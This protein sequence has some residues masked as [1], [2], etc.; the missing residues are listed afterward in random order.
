M[1]QAAPDTL[2]T[3]PDSMSAI[4]LD[5]FEGDAS[6]EPRSVSVPDLG[7]DEVLIR[8]QSA[9]VGVW[10]PAELDGYFAE[11]FDA[12]PEFPYVPGFDGAGIVAAV[13]E[14]L[15]EFEPG[16]RVY[17]AGQATPGRG[18]YAEYGVAKANNTSL[19][20][21]GLPVEQAGAMPVDAVTALQGLE[22][23]LELR[24]GELVLIFG[25]AGGVGHLAVQLAKRMGA[26]VF[27]VASGE[28]G[29]ALAENLGA[30]VAVD[31]RE[32]DVL[33]AARE[34]APDG[35]DK[36][37]LT[38]GGDTAS[39]SLEALRDGGHA[40]YPNGVQPEP[41]APEGVTLKSYDGIVN[42]RTLARLNELIAAEGVG[43]TD[44]SV[45]V[46]RTWPLSEAAEA[47]RSLDDH[48]LGKL[49]LRP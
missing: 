33:A 36:A 20:P 14:D 28:D 13:G 9:G 10:D 44:F 34:F 23:T 18:F 37:L 47:H 38:A 22:D 3:T 40:V 25:A 27:A 21:A 39:L 12:E 35:I 26:R 2:K 48:Y 15:D 7:P 17:A 11:M 4:A 29:V 19:I 24:E 49:A 43:L 31:G 42:A 5:D 41:R 45:H 8:V 46:A 16:D 32:G 30:D 6:L 1:W